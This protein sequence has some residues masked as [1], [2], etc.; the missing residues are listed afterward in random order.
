MHQGNFKH[1]TLRAV[2]VAL[3]GAALVTPTGELL[4]GYWLQETLRQNFG[5]QREKL[6]SRSLDFL[7]NTY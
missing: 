1:V 5:L 7:L 3:A 6:M 4:R 2:A